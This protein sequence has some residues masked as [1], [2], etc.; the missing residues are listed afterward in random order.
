MGT[1]TAMAPA[2]GT[3]AR[4]VGGAHGRILRHRQQR[5][6]LLEPNGRRELGLQQRPTVTPIISTL[7]AIISTLVQLS[8]LLLQLSVPLL[9]LSVPILQSSVPLLKISGPALHTAQT[10][11]Q[12][13]PL[14]PIRVLIQCVHYSQGV[15]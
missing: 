13:L 10:H 9:Q 1:A 5:E 12:S 11:A 14:L 15:L 8:V 3:E 2:C 7:V 4:G 6:P